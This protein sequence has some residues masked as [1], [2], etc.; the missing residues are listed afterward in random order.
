MKDKTYIEHHKQALIEMLGGWNMNKKKHKRL[1][2]SAFRLSAPIPLMTEPLM[3]PGV[4]F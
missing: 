1:D 2:K 3:H 4:I